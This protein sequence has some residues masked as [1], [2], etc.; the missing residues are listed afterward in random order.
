V[1]VN[2]DIGEL[3]ELKDRI[4]EKGLLRTAIKEGEF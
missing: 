4:L 2:W 3:M 1:W